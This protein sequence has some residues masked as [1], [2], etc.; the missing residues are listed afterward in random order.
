MLRQA[1]AGE[2]A[3][4]SAWAGNLS[5]SRSMIAPRIALSTIHSDEAKTSAIAH[6]RHAVRYVSLGVTIQRALTGYGPCYRP[7][8]S[9]R[10]APNLVSGSDSPGPTHLASTASG[11]LYSDRLAEV[12]HT[13]R[14]PY[15]QQRAHLQLAT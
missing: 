1:P 10:S 6:L 8:A 12:A 5:M 13:F 11:T 4:S 3:R 15:F 2:V 9:R 7:M 14:Y